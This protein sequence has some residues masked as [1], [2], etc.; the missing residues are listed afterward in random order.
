MEQIR[1]LI[2]ELKLVIHRKPWRWFTIWF[3]S[4]VWVIIS[5]RLDRCLYL[6]FGKVYPVI[7]PVFFPVFFVC[8]LV[9]GR[10]EFHY[11]ARIGRGFRILHTALGTVISGKTVAGERL[12]LVGGNLIGGRKPMKEGDILIGSHVGLG[13]HAVVLGPVTVG[14]RAQIGAGAVVVS[15]VPPGAVFVGIPARALEK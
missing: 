5:Y 1:F 9:G 10:H 2:F 4:S 7:R 11:R 3:G 8:A 12:T 14:D 15:D 6:L 13:A